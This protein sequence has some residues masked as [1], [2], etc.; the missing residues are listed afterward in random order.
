MGLPNK[1]FAKKECIPK[2]C[3][4]Q[5]AIGLLGMGCLNEYKTLRNI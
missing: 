5:G 4:A 3:C 1:A 2:T